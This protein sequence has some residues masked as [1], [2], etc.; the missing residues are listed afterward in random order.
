MIG[1]S[2]QNNQ[3]DF[4]R[5][6][7]NDESYKYFIKVNQIYICVSKEIYLTCLKSYMK[8]KYNKK[9][10]V[11]NSVQYFSDMDAATSFIYR[12]NRNIDFVH[13]I[14]IR[15]LAN[16]AIQEIYNL[17]DQYKNIAICIFLNEMTISETAKKLDIPISTVG[18]RK[19][20]IQTFLKNKLKKGEFFF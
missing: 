12:K 14:Y 8:L 16:Q 7:Y 18:K 10:E 4:K 6:R 3:M 13:Q 11:A 9:R 20:K 17:P 19:K 1:Q 2:E 15:D 5:N